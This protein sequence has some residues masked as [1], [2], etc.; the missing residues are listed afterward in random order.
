[1]KNP[2]SHTFFVGFRLLTGSFSPQ[3][4]KRSPWQWGG[5]LVE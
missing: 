3:I 4:A 5:G 1:M 2:K